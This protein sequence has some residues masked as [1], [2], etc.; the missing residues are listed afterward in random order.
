MNGTDL[1]EIIVAPPG[2]E[3]RR[4]AFE[5]RQVESRNVTY[6][7]PDSP[8]FLKSGVG[9]NL[10][11]AD[12]NIYIDLCGAFAVA[13]VGH[14]NPR[15]IAAIANQA[16]HLLHGMGDVYPTEEKV[17]LAREL[18]ALAP[19]PFEKRVYFGVT[20]AD[21]VE[22]A[23]K[24]AVMATGKS[25][26]ICFEGAYH[27]LSYGALEVTDRDHFRAPFAG[28]LGGFSRR[29]PYP[30]ETTWLENL[31]SIERALGDRTSADIGAIVVEPIQGRGGDRPA[32]I[33]WLR[34]VRDLCRADGPLLILDEVYSG[35]GR[36]GRWFACEH[37]GIA[38]DLLCVG[39]GMASGFP[40]SACIGRAE[41]MDAWPASTG[42]AIHT[43]TFLG[44]PTG[45][46]AAIASITEI[47]DRK[48][49]ER[50]E[51]FGALIDELLHDL[52][53]EAPDIVK[54]VRG[55]GMMWG[56]Q[57]CNGEIA[58]KAAVEA[59]RHG[60]LVLTSGPRSDVIALSPP[61]VISEAQVRHAIGVLKR[62]LK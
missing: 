37:A 50:A 24:T 17:V 45:C 14:S 36:T 53:R 55:R 43:S 23:L 10:Q 35:F 3:S 58:L 31:A 41:V 4:L 57:C 27:G 12:G 5:L 61:L 42:E 16:A 11:D 46:A 52:Q 25:G 60:V 30:D 8:I 21:A 54:T 47:R 2:P 49:V 6:V 56:I 20:G 26:V 34:A 1:P 28:Q 29:L 15:V 9:A 40:I 38:A 19:G 32:P 13:A 33:A 44:S 22:A 59:L 39:K 48:L 62:S 51:S 7:G 18:C